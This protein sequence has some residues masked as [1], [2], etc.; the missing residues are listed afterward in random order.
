[1]STVYSNS[2]ICGPPGI[3]VVQQRKH[4]VWWNHISLIERVL[5]LSKKKILEQQSDN[6]YF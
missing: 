5:W 2:T 1:M 3:H 6:A 4:P